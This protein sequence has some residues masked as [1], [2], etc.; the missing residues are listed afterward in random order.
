LPLKDFIP[1]KLVVIIPV[2]GNVGSLTKAVGMTEKEAGPK[3]KKA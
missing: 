3:K 1:L 2:K